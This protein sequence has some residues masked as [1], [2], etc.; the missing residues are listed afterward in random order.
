[1]ITVGDKFLAEAQRA[2]SKPT[3]VIGFVKAFLSAEAAYKSQWDAALSQTNIDTADPNY[4]N[5]VLIAKTLATAGVSQTT[6]NTN[7]YIQSGV[8]D[9]TLFSGPPPIL[10]TSDNVFIYYQN[11]TIAQDSYLDKI[12]LLVSKIQYGASAPQST[13]YI[14][15]MDGNNNVLEETISILSSAI[16]NPSTWV[17]I[18][19]AA[20]N[21]KLYAGQTYKI[22]V[23][24]SSAW[25]GGY[26]MSAF[27]SSLNP[28]SGILQRSS[29][30]PPPAETIADY[31]LA[32]EIVM[33]PRYQST[34]SIS[35][36]LDVGSVPTNNGE[37]ILEDVRDAGTTIDYHAWAS[38]TGAFTGEETDLGIIVDG[39]AITNL[40]R[41]YK[42]TATLTTSSDKLTSP[43]IQKIKANFDVW[44]RY[45]L[46]DSPLEFQGI[47]FP[48]IIMALP[49]LQYQ[50]D[51]IEGKASI[52]KISVNFLDEGFLE[53]A[54]T[55]YYLKNNEIVIYIGFDAD[56]WG[57]E[58]YIPFWRGSIVSWK[59]QTGLITLE[60]SDWAQLAKKEIPVETAGGVVIPLT[61]DNSNTPHPMDIII[62][63]LQNKINLRDSQ[64]HTASFSDAKASSQLTGWKFRRTVSKPTDAWKLIQE[65]DQ[66]A[67]CV[68]VPREDGKLYAYLFSP[69]ST[70]VAEFGNDQIKLGSVQFDARMDQTL[71]NEAIIYY[72]FHAPYQLA[73]TATWTE[74]SRALT[75]VGTAF[76]KELAVGDE[77]PIGRGQGF[78]VTAIEPYR[79]LVLSGTGDG[80]AW[81]WQFGMYSLDEQRT[82]LLSRNRVRVPPS[83]GSW[84][85]MRV[86]EP[87]AFLMTRRMLLGL[88]HRAEALAATRGG[89]S[90]HAA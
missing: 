55:G 32:F 74:N 42:I 19:F 5:E 26:V 77:V 4:P 28:Y 80:F 34:G 27:A 14:A 58:D 78:P 40:K 68:M 11:F 54:I 17:E 8:V 72:G 46:K 12:K 71:I 2:G 48:P 59:R 84:L 89:R 6:Y 53:E 39:D 3:A 18:S 29:N 67:G 70:H 31:D 35:V 60:C 15:L 45:A 33:F 82:R 61:Y 83:V 24:Q 76:A 62:D 75:G 16:L 47:P 21:L 44:D 22:Y 36:K 25:A 66:L 79:A 63:I 20:K 81:A 49:Q 51:L 37:W 23:T 69:S 85:F 9:N 7:L 87:A 30:A 56:A 64:I 88:K 38:A 50:M 1:L 90:S 41:Y 52:S 65:I 13:L 10:V 43:R 73:G 86:I 57:F